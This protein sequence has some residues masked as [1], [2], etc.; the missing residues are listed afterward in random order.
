MKIVCLMALLSASV[1]TP[2]T[3]PIDRGARWSADTIVLRRYAATEASYDVNAFWLESATGI[4][5]VDALFLQSDA[6]LLAQ[7]IRARGK[8]LLGILLTHPHVDH[9]GGVP[10]LRRAFPQVRLFATPAT[11]AEIQRTHDRG[12]QAGW[13]QAMTSDSGYGGPAHVDS[14]VPSGTELTLGGMHFRIE[15]MGPGEAANNAVIH[16]REL[17][18]LFTGDLT[19]AHAPVYV[20][21]GH[22]T[23]LLAALRLLRQRFP[24]T[25]TVYS[26]HYAAMPLEALVTANIAQVEEVRRIVKRVRD[27]PANL[28]ANGTLTATARREALRGLTALYE[29]L[30]RYGLPSGAMAGMNLPGVMASLRPEQP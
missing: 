18:V 7:M 23:P 28:A 30:V 13:L 29:P 25:M 12:I 22:A 21:E 9:F 5:V 11:A 8:P 1:A 16:Q 26:G 19:V 27:V 2:S 20:G 4:V 10:A 17:G 14:L 15:D 24:D 6:Q 3:P